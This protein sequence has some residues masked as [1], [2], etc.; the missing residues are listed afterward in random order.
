MKRLV[1]LDRDGVINR[2][3]GKGA[4]VTRESQLIVMA[5][6]LKGLRLLA[7]AGYDIAVISNQGCVSRG[8]ITK[9]ALKKMTQNLQKKVRVAGGRLNKVYY[10]YHQT[11]DRCKCKKPKT[12]LFKRAIKR[13][14]IARKK[15][16]FMGDSQE[17]IQAAKNFGCR[18]VLLLS[19]RLKKRD[20]AGLETKPDFVKKDLWE[21]AKWLI[22]K[23]S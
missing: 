2:F 22:K 16:Y 12:L 7:E 18:S 15:L 19:G 17:D 23:E 14:P 20:I 5:Q 4:Y 6:A 13:Y 21:A 1:F 3:P 9:A 11:S 10:C 8:L